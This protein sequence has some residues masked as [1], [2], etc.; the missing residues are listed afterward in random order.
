MFRVLFT[1]SYPPKKN[2]SPDEFLDMKINWLIK[3]ER[4]QD[5]EKVLKVNPE[6]GKK[7]QAIS[8]LIE[9]YL[10]LADIKSACKNASLID[11]DLQDDYLDKF[12]IYCLL[13]E[14]RREE[15]QLLFDLTKERGLKDSFFENKINFLVILAFVKDCLFSNGEKNET[16]Q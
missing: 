10:S 6:V 2:L 1:N 11:K 13:N 15:A 14:D 7:P 9:E 16:N 5:L 12:N 3:N 4:V 8:F